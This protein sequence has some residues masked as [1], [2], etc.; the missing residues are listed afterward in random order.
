[1]EIK[2]RRCSENAVAPVRATAGSAGYH[3]YSVVYKTIVPFKT[4][5]VKTDVE[6]EIRTDFYGKTV[7]SETATLLIINQIKRTQLTM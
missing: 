3:L 1:M 7:D 6:L 5:L 4:E 2:F